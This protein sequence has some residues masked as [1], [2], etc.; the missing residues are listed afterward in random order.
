[1]KEPITNS[2]VDTTVTLHSRVLSLPAAEKLL[3]RMDAK[4]KAENPFNSVNRLQVILNKAHR[5]TSLLL[6]FLQAIVHMVERQKVPADHASLTICGLSGKNGAGPQGHLRRAGFKMAA[7]Q[8]TFNRLALSLEVDGDDNGERLL[9]G[10]VHYQ[11][12]RE[13]LQGP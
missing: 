4:P 11:K 10:K 1:M 2:F 12:P 7:Q 8:F 6:W 5:D 3:L 13:L 9:K